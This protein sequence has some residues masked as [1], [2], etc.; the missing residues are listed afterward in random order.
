MPLNAEAELLSV[1]KDDEIVFPERGIGM[2][3]PLAGYGGSLIT[4]TAVPANAEND[5]TRTSSPAAVEPTV[6]PNDI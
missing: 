4:A 1:L 2:G 3:H 5:R 6:F